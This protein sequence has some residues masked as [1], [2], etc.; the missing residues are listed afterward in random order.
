MLMQRQHEAFPFECNV[1][2]ALL[3]LRTQDFK[4]FIV[5]LDFLLPCNTVPLLRCDSCAEAYCDSNI[6]SKQM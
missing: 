2:D 3:K 6:H 5:Y 4:H 1:V